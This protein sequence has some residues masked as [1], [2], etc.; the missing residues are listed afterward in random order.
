MQQVRLIT[1]YLS[2]IAACLAAFSL[3]F[4]RGF[5]NVALI[6]WI[7]SWGLEFLLCGRYSIEKPN[8]NNLHLYL[9]MVY[10]VWTMVSLLWTDN[11]YDAVLV[12]EKRI[13]FVIFPFLALFGMAKSGQYKKILFA[14]VC[15]TMVSVIVATIYGYIKFSNDT[16]AIFPSSFFNYY[17]DYNHRTYFSL[18]QIFCLI[19]LVYLK[20]DIIARLPHKSLYY[21]GLSFLYIVFSMMIYMAGGRMS[22]II[23]F[24]V[25]LVALGHSL[26]R[27][28][29]RK[30]MIIGFLL[31]LMLGGI[32]IMN[33]PR[34]KNFKFSHEQLKTFDP[35]YDLWENGFQCIKKS[36]LVIGVGVGDHDNVFNANKKPD[37]QEYFG[38]EVKAI[39]SFHNQ[40]LDTQLELGIVGG[41]I[42]LAI[43]VSVLIGIRDARTKMLLSGLVLAWVLFMLIEH[44]AYKSVTVYM[45]S[46][47]LV[48]A[49]WVKKTTVSK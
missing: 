24:L 44:V 1:Q 35:R 39:N 6:I 2:L 9:L 22:F 34:M 16:N 17:N 23:L 15:G 14:F 42:F 28:G 18:A 10:F 33:H 8:K 20:P 26:W 30:T 7:I 31:V 29:W 12:L 11:Y 27:K 41:V 36:N 43:V 5:I 21:I 19:F 40:Y 32:G 48:L 4:P 49:Y 38:E 13:S 3:S 47:S 25:T 46:F 45:F 37:F